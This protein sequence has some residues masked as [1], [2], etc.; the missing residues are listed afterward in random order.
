M[1]KVSYIAE[2]RA[3]R[4]TAVGNEAA[5]LFLAAHRLTG[6]AALDGLAG[7]PLETKPVLHQ[8]A[9]ATTTS[10][11][12]E[13]ALAAELDAFVMEN[14]NCVVFAE[15]AEQQFE[16]LPGGTLLWLR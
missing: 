3:E 2:S 16:S 7:S 14:P 15:V 4:V 12:K 5:A 8:D 9:D 13:A 1:G 11:S 10:E 6:R